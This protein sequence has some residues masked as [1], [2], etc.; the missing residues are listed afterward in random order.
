[1]ARLELRVE[2]IRQHGFPYACLLCGS[3]EDLEVKAKE[4][5]KGVPLGCLFGLFFGPIAW[6][7]L[8]VVSCMLRRGGRLKVDV[9]QCRCCSEGAS[10]IY[11]R[12]ASLAVV[13]IACFFAP[14]LY[15]FS[16]EV[17]N[18]W[19]FAGFALL[20]I[21]AFDYVWLKAQFH[22]RALKVD[23]H[24]VVL[25]IPNE[26]YPSLYQRHLDTALLY[27]SVETTGVQEE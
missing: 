3:D 20:L 17:I 15:S 24:R 10:A 14:G 13:G 23:A 18:L 21:A 26:D 19:V 12:D 11:A 22:P 6:L 2:S 1:M 9:P 16:D 25:D 5:S 7:L 27:G 8:G 4:F